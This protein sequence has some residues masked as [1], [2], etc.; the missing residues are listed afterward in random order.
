LPRNFN[1]QPA[2]KQREILAWISANV[3]PKSSAFGKWQHR[4]CQARFK[5]IFPSLD[6]LFGGRKPLRGYQITRGLAVDARGSYGNVAAPARLAAELADLIAFKTAVLPPT[7][8]YRSFRWRP[9]TATIATHNYG[10]VFGALAA[11][12]LSDAGG[13]GIP[14]KDLT[15]ALLA[16]PGVW[17]WYL[18]WRE[19]RRGFFTSSERAYIYDAK[20]LVRE[21][22]GWLRQHPQ[23]V[24]RLRPIDGLV[25]PREII[26]AQENWDA[27]CDSAYRYA[28]GRIHELTRVQ[29]IHRDPFEPIMPVLGSA[30]PLSEYKKIADEIIRLMPKEKTAP[31]NTAL[32]VRS[33]LMVRLGM[34][35]GLRQRNL[36][37][38]LLCLPGNSPRTLQELQNLEQGEIR[39]ST[40][41]QAWEVFIPASAFKNSTSL[42]FGGDHTG[43]SFQTFARCTNT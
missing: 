13:R 2:E 29:R 6:P 14:L 10:I 8:Y 20:G 26:D 39:W 9:V 7:G 41:D 15:F 36:R 4:I 23:L 16:F 38:L 22:T 27:A 3:M 31:V 18:H 32:A 40:D 17:D 1:E 34:H 11:A 42:F 19:R 5:L 12:P 43:L 28:C 25:S 33:Y 30:T 35:T 24:K 21:R 37:E